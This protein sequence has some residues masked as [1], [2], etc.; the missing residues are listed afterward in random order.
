MHNNLV[1]PSVRIGE[2]MRP[3]R[4]LQA[5]I[6]ALVQNDQANML[7]AGWYAA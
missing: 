6:L 2:S 1:P 5:A 3:R 4:Q 7:N